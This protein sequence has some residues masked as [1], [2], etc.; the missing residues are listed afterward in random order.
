MSPQPP[1]AAGKE[2]F[3]SAGAAPAR[4]MPERQFGLIDGAEE[5]WLILD[6]LVI[7][8]VVTGEFADR[9]AFYWC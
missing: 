6:G 5:A 9:R 2:R 3:S 8:T 7:L 4:P 1:N